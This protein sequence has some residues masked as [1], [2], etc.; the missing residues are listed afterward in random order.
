MKAYK[1]KINKEVGQASVG[2]HAYFSQP[3]FLEPCLQ[4]SSAF[5]PIK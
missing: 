3:G 5:T 2:K 1:T 4:N